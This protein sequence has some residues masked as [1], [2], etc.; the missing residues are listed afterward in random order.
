MNGRLQLMFIPA[1]LLIKQ[2][3]KDHCLCQQGHGSREVTTYLQLEP[4]GPLY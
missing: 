3:K 1:R 4:E 2:Y